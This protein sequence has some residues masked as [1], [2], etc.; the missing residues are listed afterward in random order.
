MSASDQKIRFVSGGAPGLGRRSSRWFDPSNAYEVA[1]DDHEEERPRHETPLEDMIE[2]MLSKPACLSQGDL[3][4]VKDIDQTIGRMDDSE[5]LT[6]PQAE[7]ITRIYRV[8]MTTMN[9]LG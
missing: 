1:R 9:L 4:W 2:Q 5:E 3:Q 8:W 7:V 6:N